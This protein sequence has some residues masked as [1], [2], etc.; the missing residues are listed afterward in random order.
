MC[1]YARH[2]TPSRRRLLRRRQAPVRPSLAML[3]L[4]RPGERQ[5]HGFLQR[6]TSKQDR[7]WDL[8]T[9][10]RQ[11]EVLLC[12]VRWVYPDNRAKPFSVAVVSLTEQAVHWRNHV[13]AEAARADMERRCAGPAP[14]AAEA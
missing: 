4:S 5:A 3:D 9:L 2:A 10:R 13:S 12:V 1:F 11:G 7:M 14:S 8:V 6:A